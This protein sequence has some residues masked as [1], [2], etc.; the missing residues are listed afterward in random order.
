VSTRDRQPY[1]WNEITVTLK[2]L[3]V[4][5]SPSDVTHTK[6][7][8]TYIPNFTASHQFVILINK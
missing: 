5:G 1:N 6:Y 2:H 3:K 8:G 7:V 4:S